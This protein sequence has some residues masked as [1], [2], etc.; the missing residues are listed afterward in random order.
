[1]ALCNISGGCRK[2]NNAKCPKQDGDNE[3]GVA[4]LGM[5]EIFRDKKMMKA[6]NKKVGN[7]SKQVA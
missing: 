5:R 3:D 1:M 2:F 7:V 6:I 4:L